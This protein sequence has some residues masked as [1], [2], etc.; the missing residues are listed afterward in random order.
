MSYQL[1]LPWGL[2]D[3]CKRKTGASTLARHKP[4][5]MLIAGTGLDKL[6]PL[7]SLNLILLQK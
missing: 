4:E 2:K 6:G 3:M 7:G 1:S 5:W